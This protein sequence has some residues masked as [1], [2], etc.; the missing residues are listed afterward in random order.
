MTRIVFLLC[1][2]AVIVA[3]CKG[4]SGSATPAASPTPTPFPTMQVTAIYQGKALV[5]WP[6]V[7]SADYNFTT[8]QPINVLD[9]ESTNVSG[10]AQFANIVAGDRYCF[11]YSLGSGAANNTAICQIVVQPTL[12]LGS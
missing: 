1:A 10:V 4:N 7:E 6:V 11:S 2:C 3:G 12:T 8:Y 5:N 9:T